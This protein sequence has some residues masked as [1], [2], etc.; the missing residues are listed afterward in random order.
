MKLGYRLH[1]YVAYYFEFWLSNTS[2]AQ[3]GGGEGGSFPCPFLKIKESALILEKNALIVFIQSPEK[4]KTNGEN[5][6]EY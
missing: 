6:R 1:I 2:G 5:E 4:T 3:L